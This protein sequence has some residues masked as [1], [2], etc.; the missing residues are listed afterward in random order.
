MAEDESIKLFCDVKSIWAGPLDVET[1]TALIRLTASEISRL[2]G[3]VDFARGMNGT[4]SNFCHFE[5]FDGSVEM[6][7]D[8]EDA[9]R[10][11]WKM[12]DKRALKR[13]EDSFR[14]LDLRTE[15][16]LLCVNTRGIYWTFVWKHSEGPILETALLS[17]EE[18]LKHLHNR[19]ASGNADGPGINHQYL[20]E[21]ETAQKT[22][23]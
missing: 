17:R 19:A 6:F 3:L 4:I 13:T 20:Q 18:L 22:P 9:D 11:E 8:H 15:M 7:L 2:L 16:D 23:A 10:E 5:V 1:G 14:L 12:L 21:A